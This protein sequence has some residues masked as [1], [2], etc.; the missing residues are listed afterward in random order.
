MM[1]VQDFVDT[2]RTAG[3]DNS[4]AEWFSA[5]RWPFTYA[6]DFYRQHAGRL[7]KQ[8]PELA[9]AKRTV[10]GSPVYGENPSFGSMLS[11]SAAA[12]V[13]SEV[14]GRETPERQAAVLAC[15]HAYLATQGMPPVTDDGHPLGGSGRD[16]TPQG[17]GAAG[18]DVTS[19]VVVVA[20][21]GHYLGVY[22]PYAAD[23]AEQVAQRL[24]DEQDASG[25]TNGD[26]FRV[27]SL[28]PART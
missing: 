10:L 7:E 15:A 17:D 3:R 24:R 1:N 11:R 13:F 2:A 6:Y 9:E 25:S 12:G 27:A 18:S 19:V 22:G 5:S 14:F 8:F 23:E 20:R 26:Q 28:S 21:D 4:P 16:T